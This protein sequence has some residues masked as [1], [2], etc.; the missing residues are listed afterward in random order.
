MLSSIGV[1]VVWVS[2]EWLWE[3]VLTGMPWGF[4]GHSQSPL[5]VM[6]QI[7]DTV[8]VHGISFWVVL[9]N[10][11]LAQTLIARRRMRAD[12]TSVGGGGDFSCCNCKLWHIPAV[13]IITI[14]G[15]HA[16]GHPAKR[17]QLP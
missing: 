9:T 7:A 11:L 15:S 10:A 12:G 8:G 3:T 1:A 16:F 2:T 17:L 5:L 14:S 4:L 6:C 13:A